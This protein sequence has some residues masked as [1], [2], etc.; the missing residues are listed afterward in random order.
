MT[1]EGENVIGD[2]GKQW[3]NKKKGQKIQQPIAERFSV[4]WLHRESE[5]TVMEKMRF[6]LTTNWVSS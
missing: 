4:W 1:K 6:L 5:E 3:N 2:D